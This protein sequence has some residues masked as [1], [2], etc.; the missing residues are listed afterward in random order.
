PVSSRLDGLAHCLI[1]IAR[2]DLGARHRTSRGLSYEQQAL[3]SGPRRGWPQP[4]VLNSQGDL[5]LPAPERTA[6][7]QLV[8]ALLGSDTLAHLGLAVRPALLFCLALRG[9]GALL[10]GNTLLLRPLPG[11]QRLTLRV[12]FF[13]CLALL[14]QCL[15]FLLGLALRLLLLLLL[16]QL[17]L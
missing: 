14:L 7:A 4:R 16:L 2:L 13:L 12:G 15:P 17:V 10:F 5:G 1:A 6:R 8:A 3:D 11:L 9:L